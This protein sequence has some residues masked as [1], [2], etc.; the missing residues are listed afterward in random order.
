MKKA[1]VYRPFLIYDETIKHASGNKTHAG[2]GLQGRLGRREDTPWL[3]P[4]YV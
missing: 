1:G 4:A 2:L 3:A